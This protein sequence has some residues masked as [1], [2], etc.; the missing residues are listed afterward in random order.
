MIPLLEAGVTLATTRGFD[1]LMKQG[2]KAQQA[3]HLLMP[4]KA[5]GKA[6][7]ALA[8]LAIA[9]Q[10]VNV[11]G[12]S[13]VVERFWAMS[14]DQLYWL[15]KAR[16]YLEG[17]SM[18]ALAGLAYRQRTLKTGGKAMQVATQAIMALRFGAQMV[19]AP[20]AFAAD[21]A[22]HLVVTSREL[23]RLL[24]PDDLVLGLY[25]NG[26]ARCYPLEVLKRP[27]LLHDS[28]GGIPVVPTYCEHSH[29]A[30]AYRDEWR[31]ERLELNVAASPNGNVAFYEGK[32]DGMIHQLEGAIGAG[33][34]AGAI[35][36][37][38]PLAFTTWQAWRT[39]HPDTTGI[40]FEQG[41]AGGAVVAMMK[42]LEALDQRGRQPLFKVRGGVDPRLPAKEPVFGIRVKGRAL[43]FTREHLRANPV[44]ELELGGEPVVV[45]YD[46]QL[47]VAA[48]YARTL[49]FKAARHGL[50]VAED[51]SGRLWQVSG[52]P[53]DDR[54]ADR[55]RPVAFA[56]DKVR[57]YAWSHFNPGTAL[58]APTK[59]VSVRA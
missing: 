33:P 6:E 3:K 45:L 37:T 50:A 32:S 1:Y 36:Q 19:S 51:T 9:P 11:F 21:A 14:L 54:D 43:A 30:V 42:G 13:P 22:G 57:W 40:W 48:C 8:A 28:V 18:A 27:H 15:Y 59:A 52:V 2:S 26:E 31:G 56:I 24:K 44:Q 35:L 4:P 23:G 39:L 47:D 16:P 58:A 7:L 17:L 41:P 29:A 49:G 25:L 55:L 5:E 38:F 53:S 12:P 10:L 34:N 46:E 20:T